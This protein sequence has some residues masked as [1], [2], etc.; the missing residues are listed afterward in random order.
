MLMANAT[1]AQNRRISGGLATAPIVNATVFVTDVINIDGPISA[2]A[3]PNRACR[4]V[5]DLSFDGAS[6]QA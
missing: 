4:V 5:Q 6:C 3:A 1:V 2:I